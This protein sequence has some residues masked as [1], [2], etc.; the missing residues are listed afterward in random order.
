MNNKDYRELQQRELVFLGSDRAITE[1][2]VRL[3]DEMA[4]RSSF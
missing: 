2:K 4:S 3:S 1:F